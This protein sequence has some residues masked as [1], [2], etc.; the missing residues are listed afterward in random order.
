MN[1][2]LLSGL[3]DVGSKLIER[4]FPDPTKA[5]AA[6]LE[7]FKLQQSGE[8]QA[9]AEATALAQAQIAVNLEEAKSELWWK[10]GWRPF[11]GWTG[12]FALAYAAIIEPF[13]R[14]IATVLFQYTGAFPVIDT[15]LT[16]QVLLGLLGLGSLR[17]FDK[18][19]GTQ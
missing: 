13:L 17:S 3:F 4:W 12:G 15:T 14:F 1:P 7:L 2:L 11:A 18:T 6:K 5:A 8:L 16:M 9:M 10:A 19:K